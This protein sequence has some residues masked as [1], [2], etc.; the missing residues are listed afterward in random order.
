MWF[1]ILLLC[2][3]ACALILIYLLAP[4]RKRD[5]APF[6][7]TLYAHR[8]LHNMDLSRPE[9]SLAAFKAAKDAGY[10]VEFDVRYTADRQVVV[11]HDDT[12][13]RMCG[14]D[15]RVDEC[16]YSELKQYSLLNTQ[17][18]VP[19]LSEVLEMLGD[20]PLLCEIKA[21]RS[22]FDTSLCEDTM[23]LLNNYNGKFC[24]ESFNPFMVRWFKQNAPQVIRGILSK[25]YS[26]QD[27]SSGV[28]RPILSSLF[29]N[30]LCR[31]DFIAYCHTD[32]RQPFLRICRWFNPPMFAWTIRTI[33]EA[34]QC[35]DVFDTYIFEGFLPSQKSE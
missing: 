11:F 14:I 29:T 24:I 19:L 26:K 33:D 34:K 25:K 31:P 8:G 1:P 12:L 21:M 30:C 16:T 22:Y 35:C 6:D 2:L 27:L 5:C 9:N 28:L 23:K 3:C 10:G 18:N 4:R 20:V 13:S 15:R 17:E 7:R 32:I